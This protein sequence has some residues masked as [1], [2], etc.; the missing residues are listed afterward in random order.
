MKSAI[1]GNDPNWG[2]VVA[3]AGYSGA[4]LDVSKVSFFI[5]DVTIMES[6]APIPFHR[7]SVVAIMSRG[8]VALTVRLGLGDYA[9][10]AWG[11]ELTEEY[12]QFNSAY[13]DVARAGGRASMAADGPIILVKIGGSTLGADD[14]SFGDIVALQQQGARPVVVHGGGPAITSWMAKMGIPAEFARGLRITDAPSLEVATAILAG[15]INKQLVAALRSLGANAVGISGADGGLL[16]GTIVEPELGLVAGA[17]D[18][19]VSL[20]DELLSG[21]YVPVIAPIAT[22]ASNAAQLLNVNADSAAGAIAAA[23][24]ATHLVF[25]TD[26]DGILNPTG[27]VIERVPAGHRR[28]SGA[29]RRGER[30]DD[31]EAGSVPGSP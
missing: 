20:L 22:E 8:E 21:G 12:V 5:N 9:A 23:L 29:L 24:G 25:L 6:G 3:A 17:L 2:R 13:H 30:R 19:D 11:C 18:V 27:H 15:L 31:P 1:H 26:V 4:E 28:E 14:T 7:E 16:R 10:T